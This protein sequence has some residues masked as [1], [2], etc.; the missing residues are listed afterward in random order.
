ML[1]GLYLASKHSQC[2]LMYIARKEGRKGIVD[3]IWLTRKVLYPI[4]SLVGYFHQILR[5]DLS[6]FL[7]RE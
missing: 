4:P 1:G 2:D 5:F 6:D 3:L 7:P